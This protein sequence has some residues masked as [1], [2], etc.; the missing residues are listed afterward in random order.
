MQ[1]SS[2]EYIIY[3]FLN[4]I[5]SWGFVS[6]QLES[7][8][9][10]LDLIEMMVGIDSVWHQRIMVLETMKFPLPFGDIDFVLS[11]SSIPVS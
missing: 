2:V 8:Y 3:N 10:N 9:H 6:V 4:L 11:L 1:V 5:R 7:Y